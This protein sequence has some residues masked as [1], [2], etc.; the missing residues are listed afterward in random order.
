MT[1][2]VPALDLVSHSPEQTRQL[3]AKLAQHLRG[4]D[5]LFLQGSLGSGKT[6]F[7][8]GLARG[9]GVRDYVQSPTFILL[10][11]HRGTLPDGTP[12]RL[13]HV[14]LYRLEEQH[15]LTTF[16]LDDCLSDPA[17]I[18]VIEWS[19]RLPEQWVDEYLVIRLEPLADT[20][21]RI[22]FFPVGARAR[23]IVE[24]LRKEVAGGTKRPAAP[25]A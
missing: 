2:R 23:E 15:E 4:G 8:Q 9:L 17:G 14:D 18:V 20:K 1:Q 3:A 7:V 10:T 13:Y 12:V 11:E 6:T 19:E 22:A 16:G 24:A 5:V 25:G 21:R